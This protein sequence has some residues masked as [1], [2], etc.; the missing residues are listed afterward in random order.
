MGRTCPIQAALWG[1]AGVGGGATLVT[2]CPGGIVGLDESP[3][4]G[5]EGVLSNCNFEVGTRCEGDTV[6]ETE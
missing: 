2:L 3:D 1:D 4:M 5:L 6:T